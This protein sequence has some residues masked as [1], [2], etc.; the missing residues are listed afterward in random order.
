MPDGSTVQVN[1]LH[2]DEEDL[3]DP[4]YNDLRENN[5]RVLVQSRAGTLIVGKHIELYNIVGWAIANGYLTSPNHLDP[6]CPGGDA[7]GNVV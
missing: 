1:Y 3:E 4:V 2:S 6:T 5:G 7:W